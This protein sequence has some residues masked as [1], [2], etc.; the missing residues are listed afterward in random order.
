V[1]VAV[2][3]VGFRN[4]D[5]IVQCLTALG[6]STYRDFRAVICENGGPE[7][8]ARLS[9]VLPPALSGGQA[10]QIIEAP[11][12]LGYAGGVNVCM[13]AAPD[14]DGWWILNPDAEPASDALEQMAARL[15]RGDCDAVGCTICT[16]EG[17]VESRGGRWRP[18]FARAESIEQGKSLDAPVDDRA[19][20]ERVSY[21]SGASMFVGRQF[22]ER[23][24]PM[25]E[26]YFLYAEEVEWCLRAQ[27]LGLKLG[28][29][30][31]ARV[32]HHQGTTTGSVADVKMRS[33]TSVYLDER[34]KLL[35]TRD[36][37][38]S[39]LPVAALVALVLIVLRFARRGAWRQVGFAADG[40]WAGLRN[41]R[42][43][44]PWI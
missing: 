33:R 6:A 29:A 26:D 16:P 8:Y 41:Q 40:W 23:A 9:A 12:N 35:V 42:G 14:A 19:I 30:S 22:L 24:G 2:C 17:K 10:V 39:L 4:S 11:G 38:G 34:N 1:T 5:D 3:I 7:A 15:A 37:F 43:V 25:R 32:L 36:R 28:V 21:L 31:A 18:L 27:A 44:P 20:E 13:A